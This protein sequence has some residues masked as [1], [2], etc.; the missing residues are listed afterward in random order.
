LEP[1]LSR[2]ELPVGL[3]DIAIVPNIRRM[4]LVATL[5]ACAGFAV[6]PSSAQNAAAAKP[7]EGRERPGNSELLTLFV[8]Y[9]MVDRRDLAASYSQ[10]LLDRGLTN[11]EWVVLIESGK[12]S[13]DAARVDQALTRAMR[14]KELEG[15]ASKI[16]KAFEQGKLE[17]AR[18]AKE[19]A[20]SIK[21]LTGPIAGK[22]MAQARLKQA[23]EYAMPQ[24]LN[25]LLDPNNAVLQQEV[26][27]LLIDM[28]KHAVVPISTALLGLPEANQQGVADVL[29]LMGDR[30]ALAYLSDVR[31][32]STSVAVKSAASRAIE[33]L[34]GTNDLSTAQLYY[35]LAEV[36]YTERQE[37]TM[38]PGEEFQLLWNFDPRTG[39]VMT[40][41]ATPVYHEAMAMGHAERSLQLAPD[42]QGTLALWIASNFKREIQT[43]A[44][45][46]NPAY[47]VAG[48]AEAGATPRREAMYFAVAAGSTIS[49]QVLERALSSNNAP[50]ARKSIASIE[51]TAGGSAMWGDTSAS[52]GMPLTRALTYPSRRV[53]YDAALALAAAQPTRAFAGS[54]QVVPTLASAARDAGALVAAVIAP[55]AEAYQP[56][57]KMLEAQGFSVLPQ[58]RT[59]DELSAPIAESPAVDLIVVYSDSG[60]NVP[61][62][63]DAVRADAKVLA[64]PVMVL[65]GVEASINLNVR[66]AADSLVAVRQTGLP[67]PTMKIAIDQLMTSAS[68][69]AIST[70]EAQA[71][72]GRSLSALRDLAV[73]GNAVLR[74]EDAMLPLIS[75]LESGSAGKDAG[76]MA[77]VGEILS[78][79]GQDRAQRAL[80][81]AANAAEGDDRVAL[82]GLVAESAKRFGNRLEARHI[83][84]V[85]ELA[86][87]T[88]DQEATAAAALMGA[89]NL[90]NADLLPLILTK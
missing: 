68:G 29:G 25:A 47:P 15:P 18:D 4:T 67:E 16:F 75:L 45:Y 36:Y 87:S 28:R 55:D 43:P 89:L 53:Q 72:A 5:V 27:R 33:K 60:L 69:G 3:L 24:L 70:E 58:G 84:R 54:N 20:E 9:V 50:L 56:L 63:I 42:N 40:A 83:T 12:A 8:H 85:I 46:V 30:I 22:L 13:G 41:L 88:S 14:I 61:G 81:D 52:S 2:E 65:A 71:Y 64:S 31:D 38:F 1:V 66:F 34:G 76:N 62:I 21:A 77:L 7:A 80:M 39:L 6:T 51:K 49:Q 17:R 44:G 37:V 48:A 23:G 57:R 79:I 32:N 73:S 74:A 19:I 90:P 82:L 11:K 59:M 35:A 78:R 86:A 10:E 26:S